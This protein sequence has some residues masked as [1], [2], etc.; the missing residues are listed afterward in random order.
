MS[1]NQRADF[2]SVHA[3]LV[4]SG[5]TST[6]VYQAMKQ[7]VADSLLTNGD[8]VH[9][10]ADNKGESTLL[11]PMQAMRK[12]EADPALK[13]LMR[14]VSAQCRRAGY[15]IPWD[16]TKPL[17]ILEIDKAFRESGI[18]SEQRLWI[19]TNLAHLGLLA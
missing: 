1:T 6:Q 5:L 15:E 16:Q 2:D 12:C 7:L 11:S 18:D 19:K 14:Q 10:V 13:P 8:A 4:K 17:S 3:S 9:A